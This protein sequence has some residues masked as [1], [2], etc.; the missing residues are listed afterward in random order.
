MSDRDYSKSG[1]ASLPSDTDTS[2]DVDELHMRETL[3]L[4]GRA[5]PSSRSQP[6]AAAKQRHRFVQDGE[7]QVIHLSGQRDGDTNAASRSRIAALEALLEAERAARTKAEQAAQ[8]ASLQMQAMETKLAHL[9]MSSRESGATERQ[10]REHLEAELQ[11]AVAERDAA[12][13]ALTAQATAAVTP[14]VKERAKRVPK[15]KAPPR[16]KEPKP[17][18]WWLSSPSAKTIA[19]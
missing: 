2:L 1:Q 19:R 10:A 11:R 18:K 13:L 16:V 6:V 17:V 12:Q 3:G 9:E 7:V 4:G 5:R 8:S 14:P 15:A